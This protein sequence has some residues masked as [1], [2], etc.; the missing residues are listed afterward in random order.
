MKA[1]AICISYSKEEA[2]IEYHPT[3]REDTKNQAL[4]EVSTMSAVAG[5]ERVVIWC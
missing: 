5:A 3:S 4:K 2:C 1:R